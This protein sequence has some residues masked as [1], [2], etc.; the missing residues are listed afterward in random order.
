MFV[1]IQAGNSALNVLGVFAETF[2]NSIASA[3][4]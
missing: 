3:H 4:W 2:P 1:A